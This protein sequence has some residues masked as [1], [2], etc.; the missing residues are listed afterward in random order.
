MRSKLI[1][2]DLQNKFAEELITFFKEERDEDIGII[3]ARNLI[4][5]FLDNLGKD[6]FNNG[7]ESS[8]QLLELKVQDLNFSLDELKQ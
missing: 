3:Q 2:E 6:I 1:S 7:I 8:K 4:E 5:F